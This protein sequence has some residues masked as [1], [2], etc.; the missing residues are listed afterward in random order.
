M[1]DYEVETY[2]AENNLNDETVRL[3][4][5]SDCLS[6][7]SASPELPGKFMRDHLEFALHT[8]IS[9]LTSG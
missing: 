1:V 6:S 4:S 5:S 7:R 2:G 9:P 3:S 8:A